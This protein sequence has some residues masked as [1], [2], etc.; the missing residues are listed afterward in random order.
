LVPTY[1]LTAY[2]GI[3]LCGEIGAFSL[4]MRITDKKKAVK[5]ERVVSEL[6][7]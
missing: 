5:V 1:N 7:I 4:I 3:K 2:E 6:E